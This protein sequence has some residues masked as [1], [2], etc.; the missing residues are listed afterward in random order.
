METNMKY[1]HFFYKRSYLAAA[2]ALAVPLL[3]SISLANTIEETIVTAD[4]RDIKLQKMPASVTVMTADDIESRSAQHLEQLLALAPNVNFSSGGSRTRYVQIR[5]IGERSQ[6]SSPINPSVG[7]IIDGVD[8]SGIG[9]AGTLFDVERVEILR[10]PQGTRYGA[11]ALAG[12]IAITSTAPS[13]DFNGYVESTLGNYDTWS[14]GAASGGTLTDGL[15]YRA[16]IQQYKSDGY[17]D[18]TFLN[19]D[20]TNGFDEFTVRTKLRWLASDNLTVDTSLFLVDIDNG[21]D[22]FSLDRNGDTL[23]D[24]PGHDRQET[25]AISVN[26]DWSVSSSLSAQFIAS[27]AD[28]DLEY[29]YDEDWSYVGIAPADEYSSTD[30]YIRDRK[31]SSLEARLLSAEDGK[32]FSDSTDWLVGI[33]FEERDVD[34]LREYT[35]AD[36]DFFSNYQT[37]NLAL[38]VETTSALSDTVN[39]TIGLR[40]EQWNADYKDSSAVDIDTNENLYGGKIVVDYQAS[41][42]NLLYASIARGYKAGGVNTDGTLNASDREFDTEYQWAYEVGIKSS[43][44]DNSLQTRVAAF[45]NDRQDVQIKSS[46]VPVGGPGEFVDY[47]NN[48]AEGSNYG[49]EI[50]SVWQA[51]NTL[52]LFANAGFLRTDIDQCDTG[53]AGLVGRDQP[54]APRYQYSAGAKFDVSDNVFLQ[55]DIEAKDEFYFSSSHDA[56]SE[57][58]ELLNAKIGYETDAWS[59]ALWGRNLTDEEVETRGFRFGNDPR[60][61]YTTNTYVQLGE[62]RIVGLT[63]RYKF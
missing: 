26:A 16:S 47:I 18:N 23:S 13:E 24:E 25:A 44:L 60:D 61:G 46:I 37:Q 59:L 6:F 9:S 58:Y 63:G 1:P 56:K 27:Y 48:A 42:D 45:Y 35:F 19:K 12:I 50:E 8:F 20:D 5:G 30:N 43:L 36:G 28:S 40:A 38:F 4:F 21:Y 62:P 7:T 14:L 52:Q 22:A 11:N 54:H 57:S 15:L 34:L 53:C 33:Y 31:N 17:V 29:G 49:L 39:L 2:I 55:L 3:P 41:D 10:G 51:T 32:I